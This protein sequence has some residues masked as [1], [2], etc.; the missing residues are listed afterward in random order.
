LVLQQQQQPQHLL[1]APLLATAK[2]LPRPLLPS[3]AVVAVTS[4]PSDEVTRSAER[5]VANL[6]KQAQQQQQQT[7]QQQ[8]FMVQL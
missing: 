1:I 7:Q 3:P 8:C 2:P 5:I 6:I 4:P